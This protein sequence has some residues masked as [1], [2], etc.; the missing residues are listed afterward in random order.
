MRAAFL[1]ERLTDM[2]SRESDVALLDLFWSNKF[3]S[4]IQKALTSKFGGE[5]GYV[6]LDSR[7]L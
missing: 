3:L 6:A 4:N 2:L 5:V 1:T 7:K